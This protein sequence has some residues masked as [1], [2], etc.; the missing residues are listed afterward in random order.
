[1]TTHPI[2][3]HQITPGAP[4]LP[5]TQ[6]RLNN[7]DIEPIMAG[8]IELCDTEQD[9]D[10]ET[11]FYTQGGQFV[12]RTGADRDRYYVVPRDDAREMLQE[13]G[14]SDEIFVQVF[15]ETASTPTP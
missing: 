9:N 8:A 1:M 11:W 12:R 6:E 2:T 13:A 7:L 10:T 14:L 4:T 5:E 15:P 3:A